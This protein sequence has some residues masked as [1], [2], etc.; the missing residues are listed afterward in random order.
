MLRTHNNL[1]ILISNYLTLHSDG[2][3]VNHTSYVQISHWC[4][5]SMVADLCLHNGEQD[6]EVCLVLFSY[7]FII[8][9]SYYLILLF[10]YRI[11]S[12]DLVDWRFSS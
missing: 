8:L 10:S 5:D 3:L 7:Y 12:W 9:I 4:N 11:N 1:T 2:G 6:Q